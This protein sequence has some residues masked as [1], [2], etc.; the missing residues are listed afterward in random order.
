MKDLVHIS[1]MNR[2]RVKRF[3]SKMKPKAVSSKL[4]DEVLPKTTQECFFS[5]SS[6]TIIQNDK[7]NLIPLSKCSNTFDFSNITHEVKEQN[8]QIEIN[9]EIEQPFSSNLSLEYESESGQ[10][11]IFNFWYSDFLYNESSVNRF[12]FSMS[13]YSIK[14][15][16]NLSTNCVDDILKLFK[17]IL[18]NPNNCPKNHSKLEAIF[19][20]DEIEKNTVYYVCP[21]CQFVSNEILHLSELTTINKQCEACKSIFMDPFIIFDYFSQ[22]KQ[23]LNKPYLF[24]QIMNRNKSTLK[25]D[26]TVIN[27]IFHGKVYQNALKS[28]PKNTK[29]ISIN[30]NTDGAPITNSRNF[31]IWPLLG[32]I[33]ELD[34]TSR[35]NFNNMVVFGNIKLKTND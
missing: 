16:H 26:S 4:P 18:P 7:E 6:K 1:K 12:D 15:K 21:K 8:K 13:V 27:D 11:E 31:S 33:S 29:L 20:P 30:L 2:D 3:R 25:K 35:E 10:N 14:V 23:L 34:Q 28:K 9:M 22:I 5:T 24:N 19:K 17:M 32:T